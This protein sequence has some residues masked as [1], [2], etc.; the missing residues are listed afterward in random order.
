MLSSTIEHAPDWDEHFPRILFGYKCGV[1]ASTCFSLHMILI[2]HIPKLQAN[3]F[4]SLLVNVY[5]EDDPI[6][7]I[8]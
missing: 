1:Q 5:D 4:L 6:M 7:L 3:N 2:G 8:E